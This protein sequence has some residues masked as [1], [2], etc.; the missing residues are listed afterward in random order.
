[1]LQILQHK[2]WP[3]LGPPSNLVHLDPYHNLTH[4]VAWD[5]MARQFWMG[6]YLVVKPWGR[7]NLVPTH[8][9][10]IGARPILTNECC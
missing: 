2:G 8:I 6:W 9:W 3:R 5:L 1:M 4:I 10:P 7:P